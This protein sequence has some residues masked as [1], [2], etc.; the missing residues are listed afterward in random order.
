MNLNDFKI[1]FITSVLLALSFP[2]FPGGVLVPVALALFLNHITKQEPRAAF[3]LGYLKGLFW[4]AFT[5]FWIAANTVAG[6]LVAITVTSL[7]YAVVWW[8]FSR[9]YHRNVSLA[10]WSF[11]VIWV[12]AEYLRHFSDLRFNW[13]NIAYTQ[14]YYLPFIQFME[15][16]GYLGI[17][18]LLGY[19]TIFIYLIFFKKQ[20]LIRNSIVL[21]ILIILPLLYGLI[22][23]N[24][25]EDKNFPTLGAGIVQPNVDPF[26]KWDLQFQDSTFKILKN[27][28][29]KLSKENPEFIVWPETATPFY[30]RYKQN[31]LY[32]VHSMVDSLG[33]YLIT[34]TPDLKYVNDNEYMTYNSAFFFTPNEMNF[35]SYNKIALVPAA[36]SMP[37]K[38][39]LPFL[40]EIDVG[41]GDFFPGTRFTVFTINR[42]IFEQYEIKNVTIPDSL[43]NSEVKVSSIICFDSV[44][45]H[46]VRQF[47]RKGARILTIITNDGWFGN[48]SGPYQHAQYAVFRAVENRVSI[49]RSANTGISFFIDPTGKKHEIVGLHER[50]VISYQL[51]ITREMTFYTRHGDWLG[52][53]CLIISIPIISYA[54]LKKGRIKS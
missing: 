22:R 16:T 12:A 25:L 33:I 52:T 2:P 54:F 13:M 14:T 8:L 45:P 26:K 4:A 1:C 51:P 28:T 41:G 31:Y 5:L 53:F 40:R 29:F 6:A 50:A 35:E 19:I 43:K 3:R 46:L 7:Q 20:Q 48:T 42:N 15:W 47:V 24:D 39:T 30:L 32:Q 10:L 38:N 36:E 17:A 34:G 11:P 49:A 21:S 37:F 23:M 27:S 44:F 9:I 18:L